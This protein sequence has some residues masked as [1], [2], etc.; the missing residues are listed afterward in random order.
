LQA[1]STDWR[2]DADTGVVL[3]AFCFM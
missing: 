3:G 2:H 1:D